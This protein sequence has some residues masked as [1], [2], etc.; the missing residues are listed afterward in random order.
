MKSTLPTPGAHSSSLQNSEKA[1]FCSLT[2]CLWYSVMAPSQPTN[3]LTVQWAV[4][5]ASITGPGAPRGYTEKDTVSPMEYS[6]LD[7][8]TGI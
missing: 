8:I 6:S 5:R 4:G 3:L 1:N 7:W 2:A